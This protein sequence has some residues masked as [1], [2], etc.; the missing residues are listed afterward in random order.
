MHAVLLTFLMLLQGPE[1]TGHADCRTNT[2]SVSDSDV[3]D[4]SLS[5]RHPTQMINPHMPAVLLTC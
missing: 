1:T 3:I 5:Q 4:K 2:W